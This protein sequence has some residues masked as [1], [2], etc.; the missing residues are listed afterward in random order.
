MSDAADL[1]LARRTDTAWRADLSLGY[2]RSGDRTVLVRRSHQ[3][4]LVVQKSLYPQGDAVCQ[5]VIVHPPGGIVG[6]DRIVLDVA[7]G[8]GTRVQL[9]TP[10]ASRWYRSAGAKATQEVALRLANDASLEWLPQE[11]IVFDGAIADWGLRVDLSGNA[12]FIGWDIVCLGRT[13]SG[14]RFTHGHLQQRITLLHDRSLTWA[15]RATLDR[16]SRLLTSPVGLNRKPVFGT[17]LAAAARVSD[18]LLNDCRT[19]AAV[20][21]DGAVTRLPRALVARYRGESSQGARAYFSALW[22]LARPSLIGRDAVPP[23]LWNT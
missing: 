8:E 20:A 17:F 5:N 9:T 6:G 22:A 14:E 1:V 15:E 16:D 3:G 23:R 4:P 13:G 12:V 2:E 7:A 10:G 11:T 19:V 21:G 18:E